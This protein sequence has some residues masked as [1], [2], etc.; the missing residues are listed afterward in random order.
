MA[1]NP[2][3]H[4]MGYILRADSGKATY[5]FSIFGITLELAFINLVSVCLKNDFFQISHAKK[6]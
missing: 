4:D 5:I 2:L 3:N 1:Y 6:M